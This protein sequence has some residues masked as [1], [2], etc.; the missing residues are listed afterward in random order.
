MSKSSKELKVLVVEDSKATIEIFLDYLAQMGVHNPMIAESGQEAIELYQRNRPDIVLLD[1]MLP[2]MDGFEVAK[3]IR[4]HER[5]GDWTAIIFLTGKTEDS[6]LARGI[7]VGGDDYLAKPISQVVLNAKIMAMQRLIEM[8]RSLVAVTHKLGESNKELQHL[9]MTDGLTGIAN[10]RFF[11][12]L[13]SREWRRCG[14]MQRPISLIMIDVDLFKLYNDT[15]SHQAGDQCL[16]EVATQVALAATRAGDL[17]ARYGGE[18][19]ALILGETGAE[20]AQWVANLIRQRVSDL[21]IPH[22]SSPFKAVTVSCGVTG[23]VPG[24][25]L[26]LQNL[27]KSADHALYSAKEQGRNRVVYTEFGHAG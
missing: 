19:F 16:K 18:E 7:A 11:D 3:K 13:L 14:R 8:Q 24:A 6:H 20:G 10:R 12:E 23:V 15:H 21:K 9:S 27:L 17:A 4:A 2:D 5:E 22:D 26:S 1:A 25:K